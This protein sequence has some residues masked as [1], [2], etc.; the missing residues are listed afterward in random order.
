[1]GVTLKNPLHE[2][3]QLWGML[4]RMSTVLRVPGQELNTLEPSVPDQALGDD[5]SLG[6]FGIASK[7][8]VDLWYFSN[9]ST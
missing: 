1:M 9:R 3:P 8:S 2:N 6:G 4:N 5:E 7:C